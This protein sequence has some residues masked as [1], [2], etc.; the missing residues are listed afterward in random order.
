MDLPMKAAA[1]TVDLL[2]PAE[3]VLMQT[4]DAAARLAQSIQRHTP[5]QR[6]KR[7][8]TPLT[9]ADLSVQAVVALA[10]E[11]VF[12]G[13][14][15]VAEEDASAFDGV[16]GHLLAERTLQLTNTLVPGLTHGDLVRLI[17]SGRGSTTSR[18]WTLDPIDGTE[19]FLRGGHYV[20][21]LALVDRHRPA[22]AMLACPTLDRDASSG[23][24]PGLMMIARRGGGTWIRPMQ[25]HR[26]E[27]VHVS[28]VRDLKA[29]RVLTS[30]SE[31]HID[32]E[33]TREAFRAAGFAHPPVLMDSQAKH[34]SIAA[35]HADLLVRIAASPDY[36]EYIW[37]HAAG[38]LA[39]EEAGGTITD[40]DGR[41]LDFRAGRRL[42]NN[43]GGVVA[44]NAHLH[45][46]M[47]EVVQLVNAT[48][49]RQGD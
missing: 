34:A 6:E 26:F 7:D 43:R 42:A 3:Q 39:I 37:D 22:L 35:G 23:G 21:S 12:P 46:L 27:R 30:H 19:G 40:L 47:M 17:D 25:S 18:F 33:R 10:L 31:S 16:E 4:V 13:V 29:A 28:E 14:P 5:A 1:E 11:R 9:V 20:V 2:D 48:N 24:N 8:R 44:A 45:Q 36:R 38:A 15:L 32:V 49:R 41:P